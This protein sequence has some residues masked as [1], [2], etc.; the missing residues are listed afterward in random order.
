MNR[1]IRKI[2]KNWTRVWLVVIILSIMIFIGHAAYTEV[3]SV[4]RVVSTTSSPGDPFS[5]NCMRTSITSRR[6]T[7]AEFP[8][9]VCNFDQN[10]PKNY[11]P[12]EITYVLTAE[13]KVK[14]NNQ[15][16]TFAEM[17]E[18][19]SAGTLSSALYQSYVTKAES[20][21]IAKTT[22]D[23]DG[24]VSD[25]DYYL[26]NSTNGYRKVFPEDTLK[27][28][29]SSSDFYTVRIPEAD[30]GAEDS[31]FFVFVT[32]QP[33]GGALSTLSARLYGAKDKEEQE[34]SWTGSIIDNSYTTIDYDFYNYV[35]TGSG[36]GSIDILWDPANIKVNK[37][38]LEEQGLTPETVASGDA[39]YGNSG[40]KDHCAG[41]SKVTLSVDSTQKSR[42]ELQ[43]YKTNEGS[44]SNPDT[45]I[46]CYF[47]QSP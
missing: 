1:L 34:A 5:S 31:L 13:L 3:S 4:K 33:S 43:L 32:A 46:A 45:Y 41:W 36:V 28:N 26:L 9:S 20:Y 7:A 30:L 11:S 23:Q 24:N 10:Y 37:Y 21:S 22:D 15:Y 27:E 19:V 39:L 42:Y 47:T 17:A 44:M 2:K 25:P 18:M 8:V 38:F 6:L 12:V 14:V 40:S 35:I 16:R 29:K